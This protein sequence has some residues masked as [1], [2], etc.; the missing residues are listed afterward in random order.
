MYHDSSSALWRTPQCIGGGF[1]SGGICVIDGGLYE[2]VPC[3]YST[4]NTPGEGY[5]ANILNC[6][7]SWHH[8]TASAT[9]KNELVIKNAYLVGESA[10]IQAGAGENGVIMLC[11]NS[12]SKEPSISGTPNAYKWQNELR[13]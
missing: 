7:V 5:S 13:A 8:N 3:T 2:C 12:Y 10:L 1:G 11:G 6:P 4:T 9:A